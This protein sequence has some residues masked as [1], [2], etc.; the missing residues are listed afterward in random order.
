LKDD[1]YGEEISACVFLKDDLVAMRR[2][3]LTYARLTLAN[4]KLPD[5]LFL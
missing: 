4:I 5:R 1:N 3:F 2:N